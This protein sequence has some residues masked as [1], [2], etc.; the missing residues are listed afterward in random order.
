MKKT[1]KNMVIEYLLITFATTWVCYGLYILIVLYKLPV[2]FKAAGACFQFI[3]ACSPFGASLIIRRKHKKLKRGQSIKHFLIGEKLKNRDVI[4]IMSYMTWKLI[5]M[6]MT[7]ELTHTYSVSILKILLYTIVGFVFGGGLE[8]YGWRGS[9]QPLMEKRFSY[10]TATALVGI[11]WGI[12]H[13]PVWFVP[14]NMHAKMNIFYFIFVVTVPVSFSLSAIH[15]YTKSNLLCG[16]YH[17]WFNA[18]AA[19]VNMKYTLWLVVF[20]VLE[21]V[22]SWVLVAALEKEKIK[23]YYS[24]RRISHN[25]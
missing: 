25:I 16:V 23:K 3:G 2:L 11:I 6:I 1:V 12:W 22:I 15:K 21:A 24:K 9:L 18:I 14:G 4:I 5:T 20:F 10:L 17:A 8:E 13:V 19:V 7:C